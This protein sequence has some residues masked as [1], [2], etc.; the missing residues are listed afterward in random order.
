MRIALPLVL[1]VAIAAAVLII[2]RDEPTAAASGSVTLV[3]DS[4][5]VG[6]EPYLRDELG[7][8][9]ISAHDRVG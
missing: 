6:A 3:G 9:T 2:S 5:N 4:L 8:W 1:A 7:G